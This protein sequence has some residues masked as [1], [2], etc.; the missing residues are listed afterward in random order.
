MAYF[1]TYQKRVTWDATKAATVHTYVRTYV[2][3]YVLTY[4]H[5]YIHTYIQLLCRYTYMLTYRHTDIQTYRHTDIQT[6]RHTDI[7]TYRHTDIQTYRQR[8]IETDR[9]RQTETDRDR[10]GHVNIY[11]S[12]KQHRAE[13][14]SCM[15]LKKKCNHLSI[16]ASNDTGL[17]F[18]SSDT[19]ARIPY[20][21]TQTQHVVCGKNSKRI[22]T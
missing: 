14:H 6:Y 12:A 2:H 18:L 13:K 3:T 10:Q 20:V 1:N 9:D 21:R 19:K 22:R 17:I 4:V 8:Q 5:T 7:Q 11:M 15:N 16:R